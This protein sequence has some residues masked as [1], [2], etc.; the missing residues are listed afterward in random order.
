M[1]ADLFCIVMFFCLIADISSAGSC[2][3]SDARIS[4]EYKGE[5]LEGLAHG[6]GKASD[7]NAMYIGEFLNGKKHGIGLFKWPNGEFAEAEWKN[8]RCEG[9]GVYYWPD[10]SRYEGFFKDGK[11]E[12]KGVF[13]WPDG[14]S[15]EG[16]WHDWIS[17]DTGTLETSKKSKDPEAVLIAGDAKKIAI[18]VKS[19]VAFISSSIAAGAYDKPENE[20]S[21][22]SDKT[23]DADE[24]FSVGKVQKYL[25]LLN[26][27]IGKIDGVLGDKTLA[28]IKKFRVES[29]LDDNTRIDDA[30]LKALK[31]R[32][33]K[34][35]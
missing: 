32:V 13:H 4:A 35:I 34:I 22:K 30:F 2:K 19:M 29:G 11:R 9:K 23:R 31:E 26:Y 7:G 8:D 25:F 27:D 1:R 17:A 15:Y 3:V 10:G 24:P 12:G 20:I 5:C 33:R 6:F 28:A 16:V 14:S 21:A 18:R